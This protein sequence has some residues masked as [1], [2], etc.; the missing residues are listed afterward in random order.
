MQAGAESGVLRRSWHV[1]RTV[2]WQMALHE[3]GETSANRVVPYVMS[4]V[5][6][7]FQ[8]TAPLYV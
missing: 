5:T 1:T 7:R 4:P 3:K 2:Q 8:R 6:C